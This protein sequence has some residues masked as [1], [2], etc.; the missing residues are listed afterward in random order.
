VDFTLIVNPDDG[1]GKSSLPPDVWVKS[2]ERL[3]SFRNVQLLGYVK[4][5]YAKRSMG[6][7]TD[8]IKKY[9]SWTSKKRSIAVDGIFLDESPYIWNETNGK[10]LSDVH[11]TIKETTGLGR[12]LIS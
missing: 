2:V 10:Y 11:R 4:I 8:Q 5:G 6:A 3:K 9:A 7:V 12:N 1:P